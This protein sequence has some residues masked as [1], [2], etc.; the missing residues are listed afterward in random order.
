MCSPM[1]FGLSM[2]G[3]S[4]QNYSNVGF[5]AG[6]TSKAASMANWSVSRI[7]PRARFGS[8]SKCPPSIIYLEASLQ[9]LAEE[10][11]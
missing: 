10:E 9:R 3:R 6:R 8:I 1:S 7:C 4:G 11:D 5:R 2:L